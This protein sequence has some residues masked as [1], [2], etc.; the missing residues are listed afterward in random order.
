MKD[1]VKLGLCNHEENYVLMQ[2]ENGK[3]KHWS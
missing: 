3:W 1:S 2:M